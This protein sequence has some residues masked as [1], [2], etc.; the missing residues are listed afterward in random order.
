MKIFKVALSTLL[1]TLTIIII[2]VLFIKLVSI[3][4]SNKE[5]IQIEVKDKYIKRK[6]SG[7]TAKDVYMVVDTNNNTY[8][9]TDLMFIGKFNSTDIYN[10]LDIGQVYTVEVTGIRNNFMSWYRNINKIIE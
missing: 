6:G 2:G 10:R 5:T 1:I 4:Y 7:E 9:I 3:E 8:E